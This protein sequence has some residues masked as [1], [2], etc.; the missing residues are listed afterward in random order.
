MFFLATEIPIYFCDVYLVT[1]AGLVA[2]FHSRII[3]D[4][5]RV[6]GKRKT[7][8]INQNV[9]CKRN[10]LFSEDCQKKSNT[11]SQHLLSIQ[12][13]IIRKKELANQSK[14]KQAS[15]CRRYRTVAFT[16]YFFLSA[17]ALLLTRVSGFHSSQISPCRRNFTAK[18]PSRGIHD[19]RT[20]NAFD[21]RSRNVHAQPVHV[22]RNYFRP[23][24]NLFSGIAEIGMGFSIGVLYSEYFIILT[25]CG[26]L[27]FSDTLERICYQGVI[28][29][30]G[31]ALFNRIVTQNGLEDT[32]NNM[33]G[34]LQPS[35]LW[36]VRVAEYLST[37]AVLGAIVALQVQSS[38]GA[39]MDGMS[40]IDINMCRA[41]RGDFSWKQEK[42]HTDGFAC[43]Y[44][45]S[46]LHKCQSLSWRYS[47]DL[48]SPPSDPSSRNLA[49]ILLLAT[50]FW[51]PLL[52][53]R[54]KHKK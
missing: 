22:L 45:N 50:N 20:N 46:E 29:Y 10:L 15:T 47:M 25:G 3:R 40:G 54:S 37:A 35:T 44:T 9:N 52:H 26:P 51:K 18:I 53:L 32:I 34:P 5:C 2:I 8:N 30:A 17:L 38:K 21:I 11:S 42:K 27:N 48:E 19:A 6:I 43:H 12:P 1:L 14:M 4:W 31:L 23:Q 24:D 49:C 39:T 33:Y 41:I 36:Q 28:V 7:K 13:T 16:R